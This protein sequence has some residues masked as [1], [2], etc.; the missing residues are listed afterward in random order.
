MPANVRRLRRDDARRI[1]VR[2]QL[3]DADR[4]P[5]LATVADRLTF[6]QLDP[7]AAV[8]PSADLVV[9]SRVGNA[10]EPAHLQQAVEHDRTMF[11]HL[12]RETEFEP[13]LAMMRPTSSLG[14]FLADMVALRSGS[15]RVVAWLEANAGFRRRVLDQLR[16]AGPL[17][18]RDIPDTSEASWESSGWTNDRNVTQLLQFL[19]ARGEIA[20]AGRRGR[21]RAVGHRRAGVPGG[22]AGR[23]GGGGPQ[24]PGRAAAAVARRRTYE[25]GW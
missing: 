2:A 16:E 18:S 25:N 17:A 10:Y 5:D 23:A 15:T 4:P 24:D 8:A 21:Q 12:S 11:E 1:A 9:W 13:A 3:L 7:T 19:A 22:H 20:V 6:L 14:L